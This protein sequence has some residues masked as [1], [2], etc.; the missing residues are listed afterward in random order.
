MEYTLKET[1]KGTSEVV[2]TG[3]YDA[4]PGDKITWTISKDAS[5]DADKMEAVVLSTGTKETLTG[6]SIIDP[7]DRIEGHMRVDMKVEDGKV[8]DAWVT[9]NLFRGM[10]LILEGKSPADAAIIAQRI[11]GVCPVSH[12]HSACF[13]GENAMGIV[14]PN[15]ARIIRNIIEGAQ[16]L[17]SN[18]LWYY[19]LMGLD[20]INP[21]DALNADPQKALD[22]AAQAG[23]STSDFAGIKAR[24]AAFAEKKQLSIFDGNWFDSADDDYK[25]P[26]EG[27]LIGTAHYLEALEMQAVS[28]EIS[29]IMGGKMPH[30]MTSLPGGTA[31]VPTAQ[32]LDDIKFRIEKLHNWVAGCMIPDAQLIGQFYLDTAATYGA[33][34][35]QYIAWGVFDAE[36]RKPE[37]RYLP[38]GVLTGDLDNN[39]HWE[40]PDETKITETTIHSFY[41][42]DGTPLNPRQGITQPQ[43]PE[44][45][46]SVNRQDRYSWCKTPR[47]DGQPYEAGP[48]SRVLVAYVRGVGK[49]KT[50]V[51]GML[52]TLSK[53]AGKKL[54]LSFLQSTLGR[55]VARAAETLYITDLMQDW[56]ADLC[57]SI[58]SGDKETF[59]SGGKADGE[60]SGMWEAPRGAL[61]H[62]EKLEGGKITKYQIIIPSTWNISPRDQNGVHGPLEQALIGVPVADLKKPLHAL[63][64]VHSF[65]PCVACSV[66]I[67]EPATGK[68][69]ETVTSPW[70]V[71]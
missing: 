44:G 36:S 63:R 70:G 65:D 47:Y 14:I 29:G 59:I 1:K 22:L 24:L 57:T 23:T 12:A 33:G 51:D 45:M 20:Y 26:S 30:I 54:G 67:S 8:T 62:Y 2:A 10:E 64:T 66:H 69:F 19:N 4:A 58:E 55:F 32:K 37:D 49:I 56:V 35:N 48:L 11:C 68:T 53:H 16:F 9:A 3:G 41:S 40:L 42:D 6:T 28:S 39:P 5:G 38:A 13:A 50:Y 21:L 43:W 15:Q 60:G 31:F 17:H 7:V 61:Y 18:I 27:N 46:D 25:L 71:R 34:V 52:E